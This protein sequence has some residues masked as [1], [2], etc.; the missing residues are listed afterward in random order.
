MGED[1]AA[2]EPLLLAEADGHL[3]RSAVIRV[4]ARRT[5]ERPSVRDPEVQP[6]GSWWRT[7]PLWSAGGGTAIADEEGLGQLG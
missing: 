3:E 5:L 4:E 6:H 2:L 1:L 7:E